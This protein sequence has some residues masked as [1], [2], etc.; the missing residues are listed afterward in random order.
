MGAAGTLLAA[1]PDL[2]E[3]SFGMASP[4]AMQALFGLYGAIGLVA[5]TRPPVQ[6]LAAD[7]SGD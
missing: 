1:L 6:G 3:R 5:A 2:A 4:V 7:C